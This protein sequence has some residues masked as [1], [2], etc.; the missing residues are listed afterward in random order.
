MIPFP[1][2]TH[3]A[4]IAASLA[5]NLSTGCSVNEVGI[6]DIERF[7]GDGAVIYRKTAPG[8]HI[9]TRRGASLTI[10]RYQ[11]ISVFAT[12]CDGPSGAAADRLRAAFS[13]SAPEMS[14][15]YTEGLSLI[16]GA[17]EI[18]LTLGVREYSLLAFK[19]KQSEFGRHLAFSSENLMATRLDLLDEKTNC[20]GGNVEE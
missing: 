1:P 8:V 7:E 3:W 4:L 6:V 12:A 18:G 9:D 17:D 15:Y 20:G 11:S 16:G 5:A 2:K 13:T 19:P 14:I 10:G